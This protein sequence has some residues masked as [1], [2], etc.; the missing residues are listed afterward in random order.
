MHHQLNSH[1]SQ[2]IQ[3]RK[4]NREVLN[5]TRQQIVSF[6]AWLFKVKDNG[7]ARLER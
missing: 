2:S 5:N 3:G 1:I 4:M 7:T 6:L